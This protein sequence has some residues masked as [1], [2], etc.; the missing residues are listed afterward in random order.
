M[1]W[2]ATPYISIPFIVEQQKGDWLLGFIVTKG[3]LLQLYSF[4]YLSRK[5]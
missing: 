3:S 1:R 2:M 5:V 4:M